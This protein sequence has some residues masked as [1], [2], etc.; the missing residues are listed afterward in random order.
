M[1]QPTEVPTAQHGPVPLNRTQRRVLGVLIEKAFCTPEY[2]PMTINAIVTGC[3]QK[4]NRDPVVTLSAVDVEDA[5]M[6][7]QK[8]GL[9]TRVYPATGRTERWRHNLKD[10]WNLDRPQRALLGELLL[11]GAQTEGDLRSRASRM[12]DIPSLEEQ[13]TLLE[14]LARSGFVRRLSP[15]TQK[16]GVVW[17][18][19]LMSPRELERV[20]QEVAAMEAAAPEPAMA[21]ARAKPEPGTSAVRISAADER[22]DTLVEQVADLKSQ[23]ESLSQQLQ[24]L[25]AAHQELATQFHALQAELGS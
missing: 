19:L 6:E 2:Y 10:V 24:Q 23:V 14:G 15:E 8:M 11:R 1:S 25:A 13:R 4:S 17:T 12:V 3:N 22:V 16:R 20:E 21:T 18:H 9:T 7:L 5:L